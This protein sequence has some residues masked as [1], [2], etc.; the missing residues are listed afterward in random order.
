M[1]E[2]RMHER[3]ARAQT[4]RWVDAQQ[5]AQKVDEESVSSLHDLLERRQVQGIR[6]NTITTRVHG[7]ELVFLELADQVVALFEQV[8][9]HWTCA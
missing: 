5:A 8:Q 9:R 3:L 6:E 1:R 2:P 7:E 4:P